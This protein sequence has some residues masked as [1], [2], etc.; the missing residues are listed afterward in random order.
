MAFEILIVNTAGEAARRVFMNA[1]VYKTQMWIIECEL[2]ADL[3]QT[4]ILPDDVPDDAEFIFIKRGL[5]VPPPFRL[6]RAL[7]P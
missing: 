4:V 1:N 6:S 3:S 2:A 5:D 7:A